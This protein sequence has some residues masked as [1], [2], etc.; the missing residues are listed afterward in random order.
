M[1]T[2]KSKVQVEALAPA[3][4][5][6]FAGF[7]SDYYNQE[8]FTNARARLPALEAKLPLE[9]AEEVKRM[10]YGI[11]RYQ[12]AAA[13]LNLQSAYEEGRLELALWEEIKDVM[14]A[15]NMPLVLEKYD[16]FKMKMAVI[17]TEQD[18][19][20]RRSI[21]LKG[22]LDYLSQLPPDTLDKAW[23][24][25]SEHQLRELSLQARDRFK[26]GER[27]QYR[28]VC[29]GILDAPS[30]TSHTFTVRNV[31]I[32]MGKPMWDQITKDVGYGL[33]Q[34]LVKML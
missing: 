28:E 18:A 12:S 20:L 27:V 26:G 24:K 25:Y 4:M 23:D 22:R 14:Q 19:K 5:F 1:E 8:L 11:G 32:Y 13:Y 3:R 10:V 17:G 2:K 15:C 31:L 7:A 29:F 33:Y 9:L 34:D 21:L 30:A 6:D 16:A